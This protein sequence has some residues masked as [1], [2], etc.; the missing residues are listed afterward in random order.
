MFKIIYSEKVIKDLIS[1]R[2]FISRDNPFYAIKTLNNFITTIE[3]LKTFP[4]IWVLKTKN[5]R[6]LIEKNYKYNIVYR[7]Q[8]NNILILAIYKHKNTW[9]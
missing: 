6:F 8:E 2:D 5:I 9:Q 1:I 4:K 7:I 3:I